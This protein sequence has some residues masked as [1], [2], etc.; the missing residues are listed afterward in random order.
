VEYARKGKYNPGKMVRFFDSL[1]K[2]GDL[3]GGHSLPG[4]LSTHPLNSERIR[5][6]KAMLQE[7]DARLKIGENDFLNRLNNLVYG[8]DPRQGYLEKGRFYHPLLRFSFAVPSG[9][10]VQNTPS[11]VTMATKDGNAAV[12]LQAE[13]YD[14]DLQSYAAKRASGNT[15]WTM[16]SDQSFRINGLSVYHQIY[17]ISQENQE[18]LAAGISYIRKGPYVY[19]FSA[20]CLSKSYSQ[21]DGTFNGIIR[22]FRQLNDSRYLNRKPK[23]I[24]LIRADGRRDLKSIFQNSGIPKELWPRFAVMNGMDISG[25]PKKGKLIKVIR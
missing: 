12:I 3:S 4:F 6:T 9:W 7:S 15:G 17:E 24:R 10:Q 23:R 5:N 13:K 20:L 18:A 25:K 19:S 2:M 22:S 21:Y 8:E 14:S 1:Q 11:Q 16:L